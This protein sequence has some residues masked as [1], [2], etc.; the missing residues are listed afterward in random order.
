MSF[1]L[2]DT[3]KEF[4]QVGLEKARQQRQEQEAKS[5]LESREFNGTDIETDYWIGSFDDKPFRGIVNAERLIHDAYSIT[6]MGMADGTLQ[7]TVYLT[8]PN[9]EPITVYG[10]VAKQLEVLCQKILKNSQHNRS[11]AKEVFDI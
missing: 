2:D 1:E 6:F 8:T 3:M 5:K 4:L 7:A 10:E 11:V 9:L